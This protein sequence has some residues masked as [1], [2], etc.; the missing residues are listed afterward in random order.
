MIRDFSAPRWAVNRLL[1][2]GVIDSSNVV[3]VLPLSGDVIIRTNVP[4][5]ML[6]TLTG[7]SQILEVLDVDS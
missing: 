1:A 3:T 6:Q 2:M 4:G 5:D 7:C